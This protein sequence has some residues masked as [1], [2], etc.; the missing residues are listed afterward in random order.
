[1]QRETQRA[2]I[3]SRIRVQ[4]INHLVKMQLIML[5]ITV[6]IVLW[7]QGS[8]ASIACFYGG[9]IAVFNTLLQRRH[10][11]NAALSAGSDAEMN[12]RKAYRCIVERWIVTIV[13]IAVGLGVLVLEPIFMLTGFVI[14]Q[15]ALLFGLN[16][17]A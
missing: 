16:N 4:P 6:L 9:G 14:I 3:D 11:I 8:S 12:L 7:W 15:F 2:M 1:V 5:V 17:R 10:L 13:L